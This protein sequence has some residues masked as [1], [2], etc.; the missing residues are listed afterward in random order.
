MLSHRSGVELMLQMDCF[1]ELL[2]PDCQPHERELQEPR[3][4][5]HVFAGVIDGPWGITPRQRGRQ[6]IGSARLCS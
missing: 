4:Q 1:R 2:G 6:A 3:R 5:M